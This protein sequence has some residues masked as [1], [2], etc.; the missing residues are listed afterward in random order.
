MRFPLLFLACVAVA[1][2]Q[3]GLHELVDRLSTRIDGRLGGQAD[4][5]HFRPL[6]PAVVD[7]VRA[8]VTAAVMAKPAKRVEYVSLTVERPR[9]GVRLLLVDAGLVFRAGGGV[10]YVPVPNQRVLLEA[11]TTTVAIEVLPLWPERMGAKPGTRLTA[12]RTNDPGVLA[13]LRTVQH[14]EA[15]D[16]V[17][18]TRYLREVDGVLLVDTRVD[19]RDVRLARWMTWSKNA[20]G[21]TEGR[22]PRD[23]IR[24]ALYAVTSGYTIQ[25]TA[26]WLRRARSLDMNPAIRRAG[27]IARQTGYLLERAGLNFRR[28]SQE[29]GDFH[30]QR[31]IAAFRTGD[32]KLAEKAFRATLERQPTN[33]RAQYNLGVTYYR[34]GR[35][36][37]SADAFLVAS[38]MRGVSGDVHYN[39][40]AALFRLGESLG[41]ARSFRKAL[42]LNPRDPDAARWLQTAD[43]ENKT[44]PKVKKKKKRRRRRK[45][46]KRRRR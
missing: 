7:P 19:N 46:R 38:G 12:V 10:D 30:L 31:G 42:A 13:V 45:R 1:H 9:P 34:M 11:Q 2:A 35:Y 33:V 23:A 20:V 39:R 14:L 4:A 40:G 36:R 3:G 21:R 44:A 18:L 29:H 32:L 6:D 17:R 25:E 5:E 41:A 24:F 15:A 8:V 28:F 26:D 27:E 16:V 22:L 43:P 37:K